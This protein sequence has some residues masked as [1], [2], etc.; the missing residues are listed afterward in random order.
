MRR[1]ELYSVIPSNEAAVHWCREKGLLRLFADC[2]ICRQAMHEVSDTS[3]DGIIWRCTRKLQGIKHDQKRSIR[4]Q[5]IFSGSHLSLKEIVYILYEWSINTSVQDTAH[6]LSIN[7]STV[8]KWYKTW[9]EIIEW[10][11]MRRMNERIGGIGEIIEI[12]E[13]QIGRRKHHRGRTPVEIWLF[14]AIERGSRPLKLVIEPVLARNSVTLTEVICRRID[15]QSRI[16]SDGWS[17]YTGLREQG[18]MHDVVNHS[19]NFVS[20]TDNNVHTQNIE[21]LWRCLRRFLA[22]KGTY[23]RRS[24]HGLIQEFIFRKSIIDPFESIIS[25]I[26]QKFGVENDQ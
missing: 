6:E 19:V 16:I 23:T 7:E 1:L 15:Q 10:W 14:G 9:R 8:V 3:V 18:F 26:E 2:S 20:P 22:T 13:C 17:A 25:V 21:N 24:L 11:G 5:S 12:D 4:H